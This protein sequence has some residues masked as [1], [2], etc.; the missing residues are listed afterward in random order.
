MIQEE[1]N[2]TEKMIPPQRRTLGDYALQQ[3]P[4]HFFS[5]ATPATTKTLE[6]K[7]TFLNLISSYQFIGMDNEDLY[8]HLFTFYEL[9]GT[10]GFEEGDTET[11]Y[12]RLFL[13]SLAGRAKEW[14]TS[15][16]NQSLRS[17]NEVEEIFLHKFFPL[18]RYIKA[19][20]NISTFRQVS[21]EAFSEAWE[22]FKMMLRR[23]P[24]HGFED[25]A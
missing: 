16:P 12:M 9:V 15:H 19:K 11:I 18:S 10:M 22:R 21:D 8:A 17:W 20:S 23:C 4:R 13:F 6:M 24:N 5:I 7:P 1:I 2:I 14:L 25:I 3:G